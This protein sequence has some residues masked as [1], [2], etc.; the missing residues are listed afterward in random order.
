MVTLYGYV[1]VT[2]CENKPKLNSPEPSSEDSFIM[3]SE[4]AEALEEEKARTSGTT[5]PSQVIRFEQF[6]SESVTLNDATNTYCC[7]TVDSGYMV[8][9]RTSQKLTI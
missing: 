4:I 5:E 1:L 2:L 3:P 9:V 7:Y 8:H 6:I